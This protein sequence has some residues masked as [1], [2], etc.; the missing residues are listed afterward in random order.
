MGNPAGSNLI[1]GFSMGSDL[2]SGVIT[3]WPL[4]SDAS[5]HSGNANH[6]R[7]CGRPSFDSQAALFDGRGAHLEIPDHPWLRL[8]S[9]CGALSRHHWRTCSACWGVPER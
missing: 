8:G 9:S 2:N 5:V 1:K 4:A 7:V 3:H 6:A